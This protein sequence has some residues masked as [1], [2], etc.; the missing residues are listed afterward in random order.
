[1]WTISMAASCRDPASM[2]NGA[3]RGNAYPYLNCSYLAAVMLRRI[4]RALLGDD[5]LSEKKLEHGCPLQVLGLIV[6]TQ[7]MGITFKPS[8]DK[9]QKWLSKIRLALKDGNLSP[10]DASKLAGACFDFP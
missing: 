4:V 3:L 10:G 1:M 8:P 6:V 7:P 5:A 9:V 2:Q